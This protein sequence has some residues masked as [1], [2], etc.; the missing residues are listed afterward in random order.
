VIETDQ[1]KSKAIEICTDIQQEQ[2][3]VLGNL[4]TIQNYF[5]ES[6]RSLEVAV[7]KEIEVK[8]VKDSFQGMISSLQKEDIG[9]SQGL[10]VPEQL[11][12]DVMLK[13]WETKLK[14]YTKITEEVVKDCHKIFG[15]IEK[16]S[17]QNETNG[18]PKS[19]EEINV[20]CH[21]LKIREEFEEKRTEIS[22]VKAVN[23]AEIEKWMIGPSS[24]LEKI[25]STGKAIV[26]QLPE[27]QR[28]FFSLEAN[29]VPEV[30][31]ALVNFLERHIRA[32]EVN[33][34]SSLPQ[35]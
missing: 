3:R 33:K 5:L 15:S 2:Q 6:K 18:L 20:D 16:D 27:L 28:N 10:S 7:S 31:K 13:V 26:N 34:E 24:K 25:K 14:E 12:G 32:T 1:F 30:P 8:I 4:E 23:M 22:N 11:R 9:Q 35:N 21:Q 29:E 17:L 19:L